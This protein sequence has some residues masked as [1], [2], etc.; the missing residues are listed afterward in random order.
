[1]KNLYKCTLITLVIFTLWSCTTKTETSQATPEKRVAIE[2]ITDYGTIILELYNETPLHRD[3][4]VKLTNEGVF[5]SVLF[6]RVIQDFMIQSGDPDS[7]YAQ[8]GDTLGNGGLD[9]TIDAEFNPTLFHKKGA[10]GAARDGNLQRASS[11]TQFYIVQ[12]GVMN[13][14]IIDINEQRINKWLQ[15]HYF[16]NDT[17]NKALV[18]S[19]QKAEDN[20]NWTVYKV[21]SDSISKLAKAN[22]YENYTI[23][24]AHREVYRTIGGTPH[25]DQ[26]YTV[27]GE[28]VKG[29][30]IIDSIAAVQ[31][32]LLDRPMNDVR[33]RTVRVLEKH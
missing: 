17:A 21:L 1:M 9:Y 7:K 24:E 28:V 15:V 10:L 30:E 26:N 13:D 8:P 23:P 4:F 31:T 6:H 25:L 32:N 12:R 5:D 18:D 22:A 27:F 20:K 16:K 3:N 19:L 29:L 2:M 11:S 14:S 33:I